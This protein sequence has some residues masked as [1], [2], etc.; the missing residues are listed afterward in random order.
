MAGGAPQSANPSQG[1]Q[2]DQL[3]ALLRNP[4]LPSMLQNADFSG[5]DP[6]NQQAIQQA[7]QR[8]QQPQM[9]APGMHA[10]ATNQGPMGAPPSPQRPEFVTGLGRPIPPVQNDGGPDRTGA[11]PGGGF[12]FDQSG[13][14]AGV[15]GQP[16]PGVQTPLQGG[17]QSGGAMQRP[18][19]LSDFRQRQGMQIKGNP[20]AQ[21]VGGGIGAFGMGRRKQQR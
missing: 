2:N 15:G 5:I 3:S 10:M 9:G 14:D 16:V 18:P 13:S 12:G 17:G 11:M 4:N 20:T 19:M 8:A 1:G 21:P 6:A 7:Y